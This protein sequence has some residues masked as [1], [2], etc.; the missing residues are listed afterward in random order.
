[1][2][3]IISNPPFGKQLST[4]EEIGPLYRDMVR[5]HD[6]VL[7]PDGRAVLLVADAPSLHE[8]AHAVGWKRTQHFRVRV[9]GQ[10]ASLSTWTK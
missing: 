2:D 5:E 6:R 9:L 7:K 4:P 3:R 8:A 1:M 10:L